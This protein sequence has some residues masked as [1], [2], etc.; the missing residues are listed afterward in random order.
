MQG[1]GER[2]AFGIRH[3]VFG[4]RHSALGEGLT[5]EGYLIADCRVPISD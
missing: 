5:V 2:T 3:S 1:I 4:I